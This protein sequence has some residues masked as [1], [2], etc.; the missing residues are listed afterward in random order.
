MRLPSADLFA[1]LMKAVSAVVEEGTFIIDESSIRLTSMDPAHI[2]LVNFELNKAATEEFS[3]SQTLEMTVSISE[4]LK[5]VKRAKKNEALTL[6]YDA[7][8]KRLEITLANPAAS[9][10]R[11][12]TL[13]VL[14]TVTGKTATPSLTFEAKSRVNA[15]ALA[16]AIDDAA[17]VSDYTKITIAPDSVALSSKGE[18][19]TQQTKFTKGGTAV[20]EITTDKEV[21]AY[22][23]LNYLE[24][25]VK[26]SKALSEEVSIE[27]SNNRPIKLT[28]PV[29]SGRL[30]FLIAPRIE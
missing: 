2:S 29:P 23:S 28:F 5:F 25:I 13:N 1:D 15:D 3:C 16:D 6:E 8:K 7:E 14:E 27:L 19:G 10:E 30:E 9:T 11:S 12:F 20:Y 24:R 4:L 18:L 17:L 22:F 21:S 26:P